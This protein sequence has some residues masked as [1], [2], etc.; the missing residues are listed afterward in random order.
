M[1]C[2]KIYG[3]VIESEIEFP[4]AFEL[5]EQPADVVVRY[6][7][8][9]EN[10]RKEKE[11]LHHTF[12]Q[13]QSL[14]WF[15]FEEEGSFLIENGTSICVEPDATA[16]EKHIRALVLGACLGTILLQRERIAIHGS[17]VVWRNK[18]I[19][20]SGRSGTGKSTICTELRNRGCLFL[21]DDTVAI[22]SE[23][24]VLYANPAYPQQK[25]C[26]DAAAAFG[27]QLQDL[28]LLNEE[29][30]KYAIRLKDSFCPDRKVI[31][32]LVI[33]EIREDYQLIVQEL[34][35]SEKLEYII[36][37]LYSNVDY[38][39]IGMNTKVFRKCM[40]FAQKV[41]IIRIARPAGLNTVET[42]VDQLISKL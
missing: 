3:L 17:A 6:G 34:R 20:L 13:N 12:K 32:A 15:Y 26:T 1:Y 4:E 2:Y 35:G 42:I 9:P 29:K 41:P 8:M 5:E 10:I 18:A 40:E 16:D 27:Y 19:I 24:D 25:L 23:A 33:L 7:M 14:K 28:I 11:E 31:A 37:N 36:K 22:T 39:Y 30:M 38:R 21:A